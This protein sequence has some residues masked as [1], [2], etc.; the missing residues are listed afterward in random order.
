MRHTSTFPSMSLALA[1]IAT[2]GICQTSNATPLVEDSFIFP[3]DL[4]AEDTP[5]TPI[6]AAP[7]TMP[8]T[9]PVDGGTSSSDIIVPAP[10]TQQSEFF[11]MIWTWMQAYPAWAGFF[12]VAILSSL[13]YFL[14]TMLGIEQ[15]EDVVEMADSYMEEKHTFS[16]AMP[17]VAMREEE[18]KEHSYESSYSST[19]ETEPQPEETPMKV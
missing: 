6:T 8:F 11:P 19:E 16:Q 3:A 9:F 7:V 14:Q 4:I 18:M 2:F 15:A 17:E 10:M 12:C 13:V 1:M 5:A